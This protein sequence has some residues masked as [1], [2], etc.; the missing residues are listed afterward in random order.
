M[1]V[2]VSVA[3]SIKSCYYHPKIKWIIFLQIAF[4]DCLITLILDFE[5]YTYANECC[6]CKLSADV[7]VPCQNV[8]SFEWLCF[9][10]ILGNKLISCI[11]EEVW[12]FYWNDN[13]WIELDIG[14]PIQSKHMRKYLLHISRINSDAML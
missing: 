4:A 2:M 6:S 10:V 7:C 5:W 3:F 14:Q 1:E 8:Y 13:S 12:L 11:L 9:C